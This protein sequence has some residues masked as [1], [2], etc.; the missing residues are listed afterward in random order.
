M[1]SDEQKPGADEE[2]HFDILT[3]DERKDATKLSGAMQIE[4]KPKEQISL[5]TFTTAVII[6][7][8]ILLFLYG[9]VLT[10][11]NP[12]ANINNT[13][14]NRTISSITGSSTSDFWQDL[15]HIFGNHYQGAILISLIGRGIFSILMIL[16][17]FYSY[18]YVKKE[19]KKSFKLYLFIFSSMVATSGPIGII[20]IIL[21][22]G[23][24]IGGAVGGIIGAF[25]AFWTLD[26]RGFI[27]A[28]S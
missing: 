28:S 12:T 25:F 27:A 20:A 18:E 2:E 10:V 21:G 9:E 15:T 3:A 1:A 13:A 19:P 5:E 11:P 8:M 16:C 4:D 23:G 14:L 26:D 24:I 22:G 7:A 6:F 17:F